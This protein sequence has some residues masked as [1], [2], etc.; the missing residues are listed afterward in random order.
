[1]QVNIKNGGRDVALV[2]S[3]ACFLTNLSQLPYFIDKGIT[4]YLNIPVWICAII[5][6]LI[7]KHQIAVKQKTILTLLE[8][9]LVFLLA[10]MFQ[11]F[12]DMEFVNSAIF[13]CLFMSTVMFFI[14]A[15][16]TRWI[17]YDGVNMIMKSYLISTTIV[18]L[19]VYLQFFSNG[20]GLDSRVY[21]FD[22]KNSFAQIVFCAVI[23]AIFSFR[24]N[25]RLWN[26]LNLVLIGFF[27]FLIMILRSRATILGLL[28]TIMLLALMKTKNRKIKRVIRITIVA[29]ILVL[30]FSPEL[31]NIIINKI[32]FAGRDV[33][34][35]DDISSGRLTIISRFPNLIKGEWLTGI[36]DLYFEC[37][38]LMTIL[39]FGLFAGTL[40]IVFSYSPM[41]YSCKRKNISKIYEI[42]FYICFGYLVNSLFEGLSPLGPGAKCYF[43]WLLYGL[44]LNKEYLLVEQLKVE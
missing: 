26:V 8:F 1:M 33:G 31:R 40:I 16:S 7:L 22:S 36:G 29:C 10:I 11:F 19:Q 38:P 32:I 27:V 13:S 3:I 42:F 41:L 12:T 4:Q 9:I 18:A 23:I 5:Y 20:L 28:C 39:N 14:G 43:I 37:F 6:L 35:L 2:I 25:S 24:K 15:W 21:L 17:D 34:N 30:I 44:L